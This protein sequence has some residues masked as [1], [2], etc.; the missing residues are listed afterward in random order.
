MRASASLHFNIKVQAQASACSYSRYY[1][2]C[3]Q[4]SHTHHTQQTSHTTILT[5]AAD[6]VPAHLHR[7]RAVAAARLPRLTERVAHSIPT[8][9]RAV[10]GACLHVL[11]APARAFTETNVWARVPGT[12][13]RVLYST[14]HPPHSDD[15]A[16]QPTP[17]TTPPLPLTAC[18]RSR[19]CTPRGSPQG[20]WRRSR[21]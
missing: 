1:P 15:R 18:R 6:A 20:S 8:E 4:T 3:L 10:I 9:A 12:H 5:R 14:V 2:A 16:R 17:T 19:R 13:R 21:P 7:G 11:P